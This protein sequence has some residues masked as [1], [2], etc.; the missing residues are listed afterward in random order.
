MIFILTHNESVEKVHP[1]LKHTVLGGHLL[2]AHLRS[3]NTEHPTHSF[4]LDLS[5]IFYQVVFSTAS[6]Q[7]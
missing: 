2:L 4:F 6:T 5:K 1:A 3:F 7:K